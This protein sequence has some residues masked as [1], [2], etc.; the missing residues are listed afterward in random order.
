[1]E[2]LA[3][4]RTPIDSES[5]NEV[6]REFRLQMPPSPQ[7]S[8]EQPLQ[9]IQPIQPKQVQ[10]I[11]E[12]IGCDSNDDIS[13]DT[14]KNLL[15]EQLG[16][17]LAMDFKRR[18][19]GQWV[20]EHL[21]EKKPHQS[22]TV[23][24]ATAPSITSSDIKLPDFKKRKVQLDDYGR[25][26][27][28]LH[29]HVEFSEPKIQESEQSCWESD[30]VPDYGF[31]SDQE[32]KVSAPINLEDLFSE[33]IEAVK[34]PIRKK[35]P[36]L[37]RKNVIAADGLCFGGSRE[38]T[39]FMRCLDKEPQ[40]FSDCIVETCQRTMGRQKQ[41]ER[42]VYIPDMKETRAAGMT[43]RDQRVQVRLFKTQQLKARRKRLVFGRSSVHGWGLF[44]Q[45]RIEAGDMVIEYV[46]EKIRQR[47]ADRREEMYAISAS[48]LF[49]IDEDAVVDATLM[50]NKARFINH[51]CCPNCTAKIISVEGDSRIV[52]YAKE[53]IQTGEE[54]TYDYKFPLEED[55]IA[56]LCGEAE[57]RGY[58]N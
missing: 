14:I 18:M 36:A 10:I 31:D 43:S 15:L 54:L 17:V 1:M 58:L 34:K 7:T 27:Q 50:G 24:A 5:K 11:E 55:K 19:I 32:Q 40:T 37:K 35:K 48:Y 46:G 8:P 25:E 33:Q 4:R 39:Y 22:V 42:I 23:A 51:S 41:L 9:P 44:A 53:D 47:V 29:G 57:C 56:C 21:Q 2:S 52:I 12:P 13:V 45:E 26:W 16:N 28:R 20:Y 38:D 6:V 3:A 49:R 30:K